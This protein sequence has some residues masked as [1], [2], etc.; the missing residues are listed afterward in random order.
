MTKT[1]PSTHRAREPFVSV[2]FGD[3]RGIGVDGATVRHMP[4][5]LQSA[6]IVLSIVGLESTC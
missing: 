1:H 6:R 3:R 4:F 5:P 2:G